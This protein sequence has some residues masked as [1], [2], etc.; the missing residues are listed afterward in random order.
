MSE[1]DLM[2]LV[3]GALKLEIMIRWAMHAAVVGAIVFAPL[4]IGHMLKRKTQ[5]T[6]GKQHHSNSATS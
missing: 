2:I 1:E 4:I 3:L 6:R 5:W